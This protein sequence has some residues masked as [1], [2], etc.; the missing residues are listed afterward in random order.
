MGKDDCD[1]HGSLRAVARGAE[2][3]GAKGEVAFVS[4]CNAALPFFAEGARWV[5]DAA[6]VNERGERFADDAG[7]EGKSPHVTSP[8][9]VVNDFGFA[10]V[11]AVSPLQRCFVKLCRIKIAKGSGVGGVV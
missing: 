7:V 6:E 4:C 2:P 10:R 3:K 1:E 8:F 11:L 5:K 9:E